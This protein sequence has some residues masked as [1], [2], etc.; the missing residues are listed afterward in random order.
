MPTGNA[1]LSF[2]GTGPDLPAVLASK[3]ITFSGS[4]KI[5]TAVFYD[6]EVP[7][8][9]RGVKGRHDALNRGLCG[10]GASAGFPIGTTVTVTGLP[11]RMT[12]HMF[13]RY[14]QGFQLANE[15]NSVMLAPR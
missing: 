5:S 4:E 9:L 8:R 3:K 11:G 15:T 6:R 1:V 14:L 13:K 7:G 12:I 2:A 10:D